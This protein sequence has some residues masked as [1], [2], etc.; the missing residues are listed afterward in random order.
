MSN[1]TPWLLRPERYWLG[2]EVPPDVRPYATHGRHLRG[3]VFKRNGTW[4]MQV[5]N[6]STGD[7][8]ASDNTN[9]YYVI[10]AQA[11]VATASARAAWSFSFRRKELL[12]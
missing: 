1:W 6:T 4:H 9:N 7:I 5:I 3:C 8:I 2:R 11:A 12:P 10:A